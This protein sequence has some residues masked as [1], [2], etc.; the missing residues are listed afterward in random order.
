MP[1]YEPLAYPLSDVENAPLFDFDFLI[2]MLFDYI[3]VNLPR[4]VDSVVC[5]DYVGLYNRHLIVV[6]G[7]EHPNDPRS[8][9]VRGLM[10][11][12]GL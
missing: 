6:E 4:H 9:V 5:L 1:P 8:Y 10:P 12:V 7:F 3:Q 2:L 11:L